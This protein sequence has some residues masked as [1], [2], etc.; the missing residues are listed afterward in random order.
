MDTASQTTVRFRLSPQQRR[1][2]A[3]QAAQ[4]RPVHHAACV[5]VL[6]GALAEGVL[7]RAVER[8]AERHEILRTL[9]RPLPGTRMPVQTIQEGLPPAWTCL[10]GEGPPPDD[11]GAAGAL[12][13]RLEGEPVAY[14]EGPVFRA[15]LLPTTPGR[16]LLA[17]DLPALSADAGTLCNLAGEVAAAYA[18][19]AAG[20]EIAAPEIQYGDV[21]EV[22]NDLLESE[23]T[24]AGRKYWAAAT[25]AARAARG[26]FVPRVA[27]RTL[28]PGLSARVRELAAAL[29]APVAAVP[30]AAWGLLLARTREATGV[31]VALDGRVY[32][33]LDTAL[34][35]FARYLPLPTAARG[36]FREVV[37]ATSAALAEHHEWQDYF[38]PLA[39]LGDGAAYAFGFDWT[40]L[41]PGREAAGVTFRLSDLRA[42]TER[43]DLRLSC[44]EQGGVVRLVIEHDQGRVSPEEAERVA[45]RFLVLLEDALRLPDAP[46]HDLE[47]LPAA[48]HERVLALGRAPGGAP[49][50][51]CIHEAF[52]A[53]AARTPDRAAVVCGGRSL[54]YAELDVGG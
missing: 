29:E 51:G 32:E 37:A 40:E 27:V 11:A 24:R 10:D 25:P 3:L 34:G 8:V 50:R 12:L 14:A 22:F 23:E 41:P 39:D 44:L 2:W 31:G 4:A 49:A 19:L 36:T 7:R 42:R 18:S 30:L 13:S 1:A 9:F 46:A 47:L 45:E 20:E 6:E 52:A 21:S 16:H 17:L 54:T 5:L 35:A 15:V 33:G 53:Q 43:F 38:D 26:E 28:E 48:E